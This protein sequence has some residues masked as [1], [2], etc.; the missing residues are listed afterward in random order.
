MLVIWYFVWAI[1][2]LCETKV[3]SFPQFLQTRNVLFTHQGEVFISG[4]PYIL[5]FPLDLRSYIREV[6]ILYNEYSKLLRHYNDLTPVPII[7][8]N[9][10][11]MSFEHLLQEEYKFARNL[12]LKIGF[13]K[14]EVVDL[15]KLCVSRC[16]GNTSRGKR[17]LDFLG[18]LLSSISGV[19]SRSQR[20]ALKAKMAEMKNL[21]L[22]MMHS[23]EEGFTV[24]NLATSE[25]ELNREFL[26]NLSDV[27][28][29][30]ENRL[31]NFTS[32]QLDF[33]KN[34][35][36]FRYLSI[37][38]F[39]ITTVKSAFETFYN[40]MVNQV[41]KLSRNIQ[42][43]LA[44]HVSPD[45]LPLNIL[46]S[47]LQAIKY[48]LPSGLSLPYSPDESLYKFYRLFTA[49]LHVEPYGFNV[50]VRFPLFS[51]SS[52]FNVYKIN[53]LPIFLPSSARV[54]LTAHYVTDLSYVAVSTDSTK[55]MFLDDSAMEICLHEDV[56]YCYSD[57]AIYAIGLLQDNCIVSLFFSKDNIQ[58]VCESQLTRV[59]VEHA[60]ATN[61]NRNLW[62][63]TTTTATRFMI[64]CTNGSSDTIIIRP[65][66]DVISVPA[67]CSASSNLITLPNQIPG[68][69]AITV[70]RPT[71]NITEL[72]IIWQPIMQE[73]TEKAYEPS[74]LDNLE[75]LNL[76][77]M[78]V[79]AL[80][81]S[82]TAF[83]VDPPIEFNTIFLD[84]GF[85]I[86]TIF[87]CLC[88]VYWLYYC[89]KRSICCMKPKRQ[90]VQ[91]IIVDRNEVHEL[92]PLPSAPLA[93]HCCE[94]EEE[95]S[96]E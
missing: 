82:L 17:S 96:N 11:I 4:Q 6:T 9:E 72:N 14:E 74:K 35:E 8:P 23:V 54:N 81:E 61:I 28:A 22:Q 48:R 13:L 40:E 20:E 84:I 70:E 73:F 44:G 26:L 33:Y 45:T 24:L 10:D 88:A 92:T 93:S 85:G 43:L 2:I 60:I 49:T 39:Q 3:T 16:V 66:I 19:S 56:H 46:K 69:H 50:E 95:N 90:R 87:V 57:S 1:T 58:D 30:I 59:K 52:A 67:D 75:K 91:T 37:K 71:L 29:D 94:N 83:Q 80:T 5:S 7:D 63:I 34:V 64:V 68:H 78:S 79:K 86:I 89:Y 62:A 55:I 51:A 41:D 27:T 32:D 65:P 31:H 47:A 53:H 21:Q 18:D 36:A 42:S 12:L 15:T 77:K 76:P 38:L 25:I